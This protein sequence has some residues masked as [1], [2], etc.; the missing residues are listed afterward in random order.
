MVAAAA[1]ARGAEDAD[2][3][4]ART[5]RVLRLSSP[6]ERA[7]ALGKVFS[8]QD[9]PEAAQAAVDYVFAREESNIAL[10]AVMPIVGIMEDKGVV[11]VLAQAARTG[12]TIRRLRAMEA[13][14]RSC[15][16]GAAEALAALLDETDVVLR[17]AATTECGR[18][19]EPAVTRRL[20]LALTDPEWTVRSAAASAL[21]RRGSRASIPSLAFAMRGGEGRL[22]DDCWFALTAIVGKS[23]GADPSR[24][25]TWWAK[26][27]GKDAP[28]AVEW[29]SPPAAFD[30]PLCWTRSRRLLFVL[31]TGDTMKD[32]IDATR[33][34]RDVV[35]AV[36]GAGK[37]LAEDLSA[38]KTKL[39]VARVHLRA[40]LR[41]LKDGV[42]F[43]VMTYA[44][45]PAFAFGRLTAA[46]ATSRRH[47][48]ARIASL[49]AGGPSNLH[50][51][52]TRAFDPK[53]KGVLESRDGPDTVVLL[54]DGAL[55]APGG[56]DR[57]EVGAE[58]QR[59]NASR[60][61]R[62]LVVATGQF[63]DTLLGR[64]S[65]GP[66]LGALVCVP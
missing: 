14:G 64:L 61:V 35:E 43:D 25:E 31:A 3:I 6:S 48:E 20:E 26:E 8:G 22:A 59:W 39:D 1:A 37:D 24:Y 10:D 44:G 47:A 32:T 57:A 36:R 19:T 12:S 54:G 16:P 29:T 30:S 42:Q 11:P 40:M 49:S 55:A 45:S 62:L 13:L 66:P 58:V 41:T 28:T 65:A 56:T 63:D 5:Q 52:L 51:A 46:D 50:G 21:A 34:S 18:R 2:Q 15:A 23:L 17:A 33:N 4:R 7:S 53:G 27:Q 60:Q 38:A 9:S